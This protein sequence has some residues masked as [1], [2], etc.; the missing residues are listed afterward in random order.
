MTLG[1]PII[2]EKITGAL[3]F[4]APFRVVHNLGIIHDFLQSFTKC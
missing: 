3:L 2:V 4:Q 1:A